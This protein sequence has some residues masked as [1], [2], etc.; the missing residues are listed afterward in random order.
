MSLAA[1]SL[2]SAR[3]AEGQGGNCSRHA[4]VATTGAPQCLPLP[5]TPW[6]QG[7]RWAA[8]REPASSPL[9]RWG[10]TAGGRATGARK[11]PPHGERLPANGVP[12]LSAR[13][14]LRGFFVTD[15][16][17]SEL[18]PRKKRWAQRWALTCPAVGGQGWGQ[19]HKHGDADS[20]YFMVPWSF[21]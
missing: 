9:P 7:T 8:P 13:R 5:L 14:V 20:P 2:P 11:V 21:L 4:G 12:L 1:L 19:D 15:W 6:G 16:T 18:P 10:W 3:W 17:L